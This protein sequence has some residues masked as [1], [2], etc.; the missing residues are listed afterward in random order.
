M[1][2]SSSRQAPQTSRM[3]IYSKYKTKQLIFQL[4]VRYKRLQ[5]AQVNPLGYKHSI[6]IDFE[7]GTLQY[8]LYRIYL[9]VCGILRIL[10]FCCLLCRVYTYI[11]YI[12]VGQSN[13]LQS[14]R[15]FPR[16]PSWRLAHNEKVCQF[17]GT[18]RYISLGNFEKYH[19]AAKFYPPFLLA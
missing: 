18:S 14:S 6:S 10:R 1:A 15:P 5:L 19:I 8:R 9:P 16:L 4:I 17:S 12:G 2:R 13:F 3:L 11:H 7:N